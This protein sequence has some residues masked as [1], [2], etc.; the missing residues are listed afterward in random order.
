[1]KLTDFAALSFDCYGTL[2]DWEAGLSAVLVSWARGRGL[3]LTEEQLLTAYAPVETAVEQAHPTDLYRD[4][5][6][7]TMRLLGTSSASRSPTRTRLGWRPRCPTGR[8]SLTLTT[9]LSLWVSGSS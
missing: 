3:D 1:M 9:L 2:I 4:V 6:G 8:R 7:R 5:L